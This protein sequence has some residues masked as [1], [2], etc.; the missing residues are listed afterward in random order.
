MNTH[1]DS[2]NNNR[3]ILTHSDT[4][5]G[6]VLIVLGLVAAWM[7][8]DFDNRSR[9]YPQTLSVIM[10][11]FGL[12][13]IVKAFLGK[14]SHTSFASPSKV[15]LSAGTIII[16]WIS[17]ITNGLGYI[18]PTFLMELAFL[19]A[20]GFRGWAKRSLLHY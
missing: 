19:L 2:G 7:A 13:I 5:I 8:N 11:I 10:A 15:A 4:W 1:S 3:G 20:C 17:A 12:I 18:L 9:T 16:L 14:G 6:L